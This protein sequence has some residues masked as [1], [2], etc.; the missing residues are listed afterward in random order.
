MDFCPKCGHYK[1]KLIE[2]TNHIIDKTTYED[3]IFICPNCNTK[4]HETYSFNLTLAG[5][6]IKEVD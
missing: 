2:T 3:S 5:H 1:L 4:Y 6:E